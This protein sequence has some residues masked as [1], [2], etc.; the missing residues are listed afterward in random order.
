MAEI[1][2][3][4]GTIKF[5]LFPSKAPK[6]VENFQ[7]LAEKDYYDGIIFHRVID[8]FMIQTGDPT[9]TGTGG[10]S[11]WGGSF[12]DEIRT[13]LTHMHGAVSMAN[14]GTDTNG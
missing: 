11:A 5:K 13:D 9:G 8:D 3:T 7:I 10:E 6:T 14:K 4:E 2:T 12:E 1:E